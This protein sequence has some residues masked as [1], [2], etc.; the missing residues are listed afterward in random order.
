MAT[1]IVAGIAA[2]IKDAKPSLNHQ[3]IVDIIMN[4][5]V[6][7]N[8]LNGLVKSGQVVNARDAVLDALN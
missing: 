4:S 5:G 7:V 8:E 1:P 6:N 2:L 3:Q